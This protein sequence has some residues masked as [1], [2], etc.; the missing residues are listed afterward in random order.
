M[1]A[2]S[3]ILNIDQGSTF[4]RKLIF[5]DSNNV[6]VDLTG[7]VFTGKIKKNVT[8]TLEV[9]SFSFTVLN[10]TTNLGE[11]TFELSDEASSAIVL[12]TQKGAKRTPEEFAYDIERAFPNGEV[13]RILQGIVKISPEVT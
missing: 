4:K 5:R 7:Q 12:K 6:L 10:Q 13:E 3:L 8:D 1:S 9:A 11:V 2:A